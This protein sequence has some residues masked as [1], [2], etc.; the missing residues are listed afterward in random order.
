MLR[1]KT[2]KLG[3]KRIQNGKGERGNL[4]ISQCEPDAR[5]HVSSL[6]G[7]VNHVLCFD[8]LVSQKLRL[9]IVDDVLRLVKNWPQPSKYF[10]GMLAFLIKGLFTYDVHVRICILAR[11]PCHRTRQLSLSPS[12]GPSSRETGGK[13]RRA[14]GLA[15]FRNRS[16]EY[17]AKICALLFLPPPLHPCPRVRHLS[18]P[19]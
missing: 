1:H 8:R 10:K 17:L 16:L 12:K 15:S 13:W 19:N 11:S 2:S 18:R 3:L 4:E 5:R 7:W 6:L 9:P 14:C